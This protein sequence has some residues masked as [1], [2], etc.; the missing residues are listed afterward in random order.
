[1]PKGDAKHGS[2]KPGYGGSIPLAASKIQIMKK[3]KGKK[4]LLHGLTPPI[5]IDADTKFPYFFDLMWDIKRGDQVL[6]NQ[7]NILDDPT[8][9]DALARYGYDAQ[10]IRN[11]LKLQDFLDSDSDQFQL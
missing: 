11:R 10:D 5:K 3:N 4:N 8:F 9:F 7:F 6:R 1:M 2:A